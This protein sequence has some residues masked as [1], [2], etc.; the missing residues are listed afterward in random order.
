MSSTTTASSS[1]Q[2]LSSSFQLLTRNYKATTPPRVKLIDSFLLFL[3]LT[4][5]AQFAYRI[6]V[7][8]YP[9]NAFLAG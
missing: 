6:L 1:A 8:S 7:T 2:D 4:G 5:V 3:V 9:F